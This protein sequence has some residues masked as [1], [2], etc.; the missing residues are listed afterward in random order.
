MASDAAPEGLGRRRFLTLV[1]LAGLGVMARPG[2]TV[3]QSPTPA[4][5]TTPPPA[6]PPP[7]AQGPSE[8]ARA[9]VG[10]LQRRYANRLSA[11]QWE[12]V[13]RDVDGDLAAGKRL[14][15]AKL[16][17]ADEPDMVFRP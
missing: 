7:A 12:G 9:I 15:E 3:A 4:A 1:G 6:T 13:M 5:T 10:V 16:V 8:D 2:E 14:R 17:N 11:E